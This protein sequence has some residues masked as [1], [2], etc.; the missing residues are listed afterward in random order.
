[1]E[2]KKDRKTWV[3]DLETLASCFT[4]TSKN[5][6]TLEIK[7][8]VLHKDRWEW[9]ELMEHLEDCNAMIGFNNINFDYPVLHFMIKNKIG[10]HPSRQHIIHQIYTE[11]QR[12]INDKSPFGSGIR[13]N[14]ILIP[15]LDLFRLWHFNNKVRMQSLKG[16]E[17]AMK[18]P[19]V[20]DMPIGHEKGD[21]SIE[22]VDEILDY[23]LNDVEATFEFYKR[24]I[25]KINLRKDL[26]KTYNLNSANFPDSKIGE[27][28]TLKLYCE[29]TGQSIWD[30]KKMR[31]E[32]PRIALG[33]C[34]FEYIHFE[35]PEFNNLLKKLKSQIISGTKGEFAE[36]VVFK[37]FK[38]D[39]GLGGLHASV[40]PGI[41]ISNDEYI[42]RDIDVNSMYPNIVI[43]NGLYPAHL[44]PEFC[45][46][47]ENIVKMR[48]EA[49]KAGNTV[50]SDGMKLAANAT[51]GKSNDKYSF[52]YDPLYTLTTTVKLA[53][54]K[55]G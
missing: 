25:D 5:V 33:D 52:M 29:R 36:S 32:R 49:K 8:F 34:I 43:Q 16:L 42:I 55:G 22:E 48:L 28:L 45:K 1:M 30:V 23:N 20:Q 14:E 18:F 6:D 37:G 3:Y 24:S 46:V 38:Y 51:Y 41:Y 53:V 9:D 2:I 21:I 15:Q 26:N 10:C 54:L 17:I 13:Q 47:Y 12:I 27:E 7:Q 31:T 40:E 39:F 35:T 4:M 50:L 44:G 11:V 19:N